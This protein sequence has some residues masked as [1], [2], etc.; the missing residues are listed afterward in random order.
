MAAEVPGPRRCRY[1]RTSMILGREIL[2]VLTG[3][4]FVLNLRRQRSL[5][6]LVFGRL[7][8]RC[9]TGLH[10]A[11]ASVETSGRKCY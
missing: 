9:G 3:C 6:L 5:V 2:P 4:L 7:F 8:L 1:R 10:S 11:R